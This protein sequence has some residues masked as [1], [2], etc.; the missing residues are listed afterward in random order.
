MHNFAESP[1]IQLTSNVLVFDSK[2]EA[3][4][5]CKVA[6]GYP[7]IHNMSLVK[8]GQVIVNRVSSEINYT[9]SGGLPQKVYGSY[10]CIV[11]NTAGISSRAI[12]L[13]HKGACFSNVLVVMSFGSYQ[14]DDTVILRFSLH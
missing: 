1:E 12:L 9:T 6:G 10:S 7:P 13:Q 3:T 5:R 2:E 14:D 8:N 11:N 4:L